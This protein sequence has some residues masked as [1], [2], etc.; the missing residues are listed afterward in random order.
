[1][2]LAQLLCSAV[3]NSWVRFKDHLIRCEVN[4]ADDC[5]AKHD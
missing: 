3:L 1:M 5:V 4:F 2:I